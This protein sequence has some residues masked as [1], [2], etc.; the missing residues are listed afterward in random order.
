MKKKLSID[1]LNL[2][3]NER[4]SR[5]L[6]VLGTFSLIGLSFKKLLYILGRVFNAI[7]VHSNVPFGAEHIWIPAFLSDITLIFFASI[8]YCFS[9][10]Y[11]FTSYS[12]KEQTT[13]YQVTADE[14]YKKLLGIL[15]ICIML[16]VS[17]ILI[18][19]VTFVITDDIPKV[20]ILL[21]FCI[22]L[23]F[24]LLDRKNLYTQFKEFT[25]TFTLDKNGIVLYVVLWF[26]L[27]LIFFTLG[28]YQVGYSEKSYATFKFNNQS[29]I[30]L[31]IQFE[32]KVPKE[33]IIQSDIPEM[34]PIIIQEDDFFMSYVEATKEN[35][36]KPTDLSPVT[37]QFIYKQSFYE[38]NYKI[39]IDK[40]IRQGKNSII[41]TFKTDDI[42]N[43]KKSYKI[44]NQINNN[45]GKYELFKQ[46]FNVYLD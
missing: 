27:G 22:I 8:I 11:N 25:Q 33:I 30:N 29:T 5:M 9:E 44:V 15:I 2:K 38:Y 19:I 37:N 14:R 39:N 20:I 31:D 7:Y 42:V 34:K 45:N 32:N 26:S 12:K 4:I 1:A 36:N 6:L 23:I 43:I 35:F 21:G 3:Y 10:L 24:I 46:E 40:L 28:A 18:T 41:I 13:K 17:T 16:T